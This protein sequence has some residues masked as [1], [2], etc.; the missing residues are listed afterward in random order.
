AEA[1][2][3]TDRTDMLAYLRECA[4]VAEGTGHKNIAGLTRAVADRL[5]AEFAEQTPSL[6]VPT[7]ER[8]HNTWIYYFA[9]QW[10]MPAQY[11]SL[12]LKM[13]A[14][15]EGQEAMKNVAQFI[16]KNVCPSNPQPV[17]ITTVFPL[18]SEY[19][20]PLLVP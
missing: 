17:V 10:G 11:G 8:A 20:S 9:F 16:T 5:A 15:L 18:G 13:P 3:Q 12:T 19:V 4:G 14:P 1:I 2:A 6:V 7:T